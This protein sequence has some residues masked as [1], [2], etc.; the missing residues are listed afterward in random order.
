MVILQA[1]AAIQ[2]SSSYDCVAGHYSLPFSTQYQVLLTG[3]FSAEAPGAALYVATA[4]QTSVLFQ[5]HPSSWVYSTGLV[6]AS[7]FAV[8]IPQATTSS[9]SRGLT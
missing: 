1:G 6:N 3:G 5:G 2:V 4:Q 7:R 9:G 8:D